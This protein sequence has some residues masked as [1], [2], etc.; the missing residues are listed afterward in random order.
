MN[1][2]SFT[3][4]LAVKTRRPNILNTIQENSIRIKEDNQILYGYSGFNQYPNK[5]TFYPTYGCCEIPYPDKY[6]FYKGIIFDGEDL[7][8]V[9]EIDEQIIFAAL[10][11]D[12][13]LIDKWNS[14][15]NQFLSEIAEKSIETNGEIFLKSIADLKKLNINVKIL[16]LR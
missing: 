15:L 12:E 5:D 11:K 10:K 13:S 7:A 3:G 1:L 9:K 16:H 14:V 4:A 2:I 6:G 8:K